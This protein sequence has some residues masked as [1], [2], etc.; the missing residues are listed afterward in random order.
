MRNQCCQ[1]PCPPV[2]CPMKL[3][4][5]CILYDGIYLPNMQISAGDTLANILLKIDTLA[6]SDLASVSTSPTDSIHFSGLGTVLNPL[7]ADVQ[8]SIDAGNIITLLPDGLYVAAPVIPPQVNIYNSDG[9]LTANRIV[10]GNSN[11]LAFDEISQ[12]TINANSYYWQNSTTG[13]SIA[14]DGLSLAINGGGPTGGVSISSGANTSIDIGAAPAS[15]VGIV[16]PGFPN[17]GGQFLTTDALGKLTLAT[18]PTPATS[19][20]QQVTTAG[21]TTTNNMTIAPATNTSGAMTITGTGTGG[22]TFQ[23]TSQFGNSAMLRT[24][25]SLSEMRVVNGTTASITVDGATS[26]I[27]LQNNGSIVFGT[28]SSSI[29]YSPGGL[30]F[31]DNTAV[32]TNR[33]TADGRMTGTAASTSNQFTTLSQLTAISATIVATSLASTA[34]TQAYMNTNHAAVAI[35]SSV[36]FTNLSDDATKVLV[37]N[38]TGATTWSSNAD[39]K[40]T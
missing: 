11:A 4:T 10:D 6:G 26:T 19:N 1:A 39:L 24:F 34:I 27:T 7:T 37:V 16:F 32:E 9:E 17:P 3:G 33:I 28:L 2:G 12:F 38:K 15:N 5:M 31:R 25:P 13:A 18:V 20:L 22:A 29:Q 30:I 23:A 35:G 40:L 14:Y 21:N 8:I 36:W